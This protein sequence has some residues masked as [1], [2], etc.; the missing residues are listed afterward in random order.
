METL[1][2]TAPSTGTRVEEIVTEACL[3]LWCSLFSLSPL[4]AIHAS[5]YMTCDSLLVTFTEPAL[6]SATIRSLTTTKRTEIKDV[7]GMNC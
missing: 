7:G 5:Q 2:V 6:V 4:Y 3:L 1:S